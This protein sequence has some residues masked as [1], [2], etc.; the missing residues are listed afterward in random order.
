[1]SF[2]SFQL[3][4]NPRTNTKLIPNEPEYLPN[5]FY[6]GQRVYYKSL[7]SNHHR[8]GTV[9]KINQR[10]GSAFISENYINN[11]WANWDDGSQP[12]FMPKDRVYPA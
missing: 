11:V 3:K 6:V 4:I 2:K 10:L 5:G 7:Y 1:M 8:Y 9:V 12:G